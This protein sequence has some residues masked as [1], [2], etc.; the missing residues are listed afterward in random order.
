[1]CHYKDWQ[2]SKSGQFP[3]DTAMLSASNAQVKWEGQQLTG[4]NTQSGFTFTCHIDADAQSKSAFSQVGTGTL[5]IWAPA[6]LAV[7]NC[8]KDNGRVL[9]SNAHTGAP[10][11]SIHYRTNVSLPL[12]RLNPG[13]QHTHTSEQSGA[14]RE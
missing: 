12:V 10:V 13:G 5:P 6:G 9:F 3:D 4:K 7:F 8:Y 14:V 11:Q 1:M 2:N